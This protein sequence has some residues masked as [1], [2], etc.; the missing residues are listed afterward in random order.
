MT[1]IDFYLLENNSPGGTDR[2][3]CR[4]AEKAYLLGHRIF[5]H[6]TSPAH[7]TALDQLL[8]TFKQNSFVPHAVHPVDDTQAPPV[9]LG[10]E[11]GPDSHT[12]VLINLSGS[13]PGFFSSFERVAEL[14]GPEAAQRGL[15]RERFRYYRERG[16]ELSTHN[17]NQA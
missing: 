5:I 14:V 8:W 9:L 1:R 16:Y 11:S 4:L 17:L 2:V 12:D 7:T 15:A 3:A 6:T 10:H 13:V